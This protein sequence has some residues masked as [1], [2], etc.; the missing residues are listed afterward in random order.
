MNSASTKQA[1]RTLAF[2]SL[3]SMLPAQVLTRADAT[4]FMEAI[5]D[6]FE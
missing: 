3:S 2:S 1:V 6:L 5:D 4:D